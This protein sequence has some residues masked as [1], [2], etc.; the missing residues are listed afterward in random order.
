MCPEL[1]HA[2]AVNGHSPLG[3][4]SVDDPPPPTRRIVSAGGVDAPD[5]R[6]IEDQV[7]LLPEWDERAER[8]RH[9][10]CAVHVAPRRATGPALPL[11]SVDVRRMQRAL[12]P[13]T[14]GV[15]PP[16]RDLAG[17][18][19]DVHAVVRHRV[20]VRAGRDDGRQEALWRA[21]GRTA[22]RWSY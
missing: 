17:A 5:T 20:D 7:V 13:L 22:R 6:F 16:H 19:L 11:R 10:H 8:V 3:P 2:S 4:V 1:A 15:G 9:D 14:R 21:R 12:R 18:E